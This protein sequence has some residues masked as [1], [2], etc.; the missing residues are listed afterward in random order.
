M[1]LP[2]IEGQL[3]GEFQ[4]A[5]LKTEILYQN[6]R[7]AAPQVPQKPSVAGLRVSSGSV[8]DQSELQ[9][10]TMTQKAGRGLGPQLSRWNV[11]YP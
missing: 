9:S 11:L 3:H 7:G 5:R 1:G 2:L 10:K 4:F 8:Q 6:K